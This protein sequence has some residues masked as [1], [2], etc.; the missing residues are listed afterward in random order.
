MRIS[1]A[2]PDNRGFILVTVL[3]VI[4]VLL[5]LVLA[6]SSKVQLNLMEAENFRNS[7]QALRF[8]QNGITGAIGI[9]K[10]D[11]TSY[12][13][14]KDTWATNIPSLALGDRTSQ[15]SLLITITDEDGKIPINNLVVNSRITSASDDK[16]DKSIFGSTNVSTKTTA[17]SSD[18]SKDFE[19]RLRAL[20]ARLGGNPEIVNALIDWLDSDD[21]PSGNEG[22]ESEY[23]KALE[24]PCKN[25][26]LDSIDELLMIK[27]F[28][29]EL[30]IDKG[31]KDYLTIAPITGGVNVN[32]APTEVLHVVLGTKT[33]TGLPDPLSESVIEDLVRYRDDH[34]FR[35]IDDIG[36]PIKLS[37]S[38]LGKIKGLVKVN[39]SFFTIKSKY[40]IGKI[41]KT[42]EVLVKRDNGKVIITSWREF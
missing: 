12:D 17:A 19:A 18:N 28:T 39:S 40:T 3:I 13:S 31:L 5:P 33:S 42:V 27:G 22:A 32:T 24:Y 10:A 23:Y 29:K 35:K 11:D 9:L 25:G 15:G 8:A 2:H 4:A 16:A 37:A 20:I 38:D 36:S 26:L 34:E 14:F 7:I 6:F 41:A 21:E 30:V 1:R